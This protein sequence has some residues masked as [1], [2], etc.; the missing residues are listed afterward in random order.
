VGIFRGLLLG[1]SS[2][3][4]SASRGLDCDAGMIPACLHDNK[5]EIAHIEDSQFYL[6]SHCARLKNWLNFLPFA[7]LAAKHQN[8]ISARL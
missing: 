6:L 7:A 2:A 5:E 4:L 8:D 3:L 1:L